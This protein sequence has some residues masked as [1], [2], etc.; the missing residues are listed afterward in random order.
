MAPSLDIRTLSFAA[1]VIAAILF[2]YMSHMQLSRKTYPGFRHWTL[3]ALVSGTGS[4]LVTLRGLVPDLISIVG[5]NFLIILA[6]MLVCRGLAIFGGQRPK[7]WPDAGLMI[8]Y[9]GLICWF[10]YG[11]ASVNWRIILFSL[12]DGYYALRAAR[13]AAVEVAGLLRVRNW[14]LIATMAGMGTFFL[15]RAVLTFLWERQITDF[16]DGGTLQVITFLVSFL[17]HILIFT[18]LIFLNIQRLELDL[19]TAQEEVKVLGGLLPMCANCKRIRDD[20]GYWHQ[21]ERYI[22]AHSQAEFTHG[23]CPQCLQELY[24]EVAGKVLPEAADSRP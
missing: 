8:V 19:T 10:T 1:A 20:S 24:P 22:A 13:L 18:G 3:A 21:V 9:M 2:G 15:L 14:Q 23:I 16:M 12:C 6:I 5:A 4:V 11:P 7:A 17:A